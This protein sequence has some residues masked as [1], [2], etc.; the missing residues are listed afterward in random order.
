MGY[1]VL[2]TGSFQYYLDKPVIWVKDIFELRE[3]VKMPEQFLLIT[4]EK[5]FLG[6][7]QEVNK[8]LF[9]VFKA[10]DMVLLS[11]RRR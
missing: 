3:K 1:N 2:N 11:N 8:H 9:L 4:N 10:G 6:F 5:D 7:G